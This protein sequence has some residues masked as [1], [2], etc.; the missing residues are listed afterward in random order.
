MRLVISAALLGAS[1][2]AA[3]AFADGPAPAAAPATATKFS[4]ETTDLGTLM[5]NPAAKAVLDKHLPG[6]TGNA[7]IQMAR[8]L[9]LKALQQFAGDMITDAK[10]G[11]IQFD[12]DKIK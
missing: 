2:V 1:L 8:S 7:Q 5:D 6:L 4:V 11:D 10:L 3:P 9:T 12:L